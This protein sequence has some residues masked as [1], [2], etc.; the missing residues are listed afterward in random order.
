MFFTGRILDAELP[1]PP[2][3]QANRSRLRTI[4]NDWL[5][6]SHFFQSSLLSICMNE[7]TS[8]SKALSMQRQEVIEA[9]GSR[10][11]YERCVNA[12]WLKPV[13]QTGRLTLFDR[14]DVAQVWERL[15]QEGQPD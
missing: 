1:S 12:G 4:F 13:I 7:E 9:F 5:Q 15:K 6:N 3:N 8:P 14:E 11:L 10:T 2:Q